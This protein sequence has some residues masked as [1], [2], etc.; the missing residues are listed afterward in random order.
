MNIEAKNK[1][2][3]VQSTKLRLTFMSVQYI[4][5]LYK[6]QFIKIIVTIEFLN[7]IKIF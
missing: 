2:S 4:F 1:P 5:L 7:I 3:C 6:D